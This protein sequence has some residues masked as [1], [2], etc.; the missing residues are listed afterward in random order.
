MVKAIE[1]GI[2]QD[3][4][5]GSNVDVA[6][7]TRGKV[8]YKRSIRSDNKKVYSK[9]DGYTFDKER[10]KVLNEYRQKGLITVEQGAQPMDL[11]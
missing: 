8:E 1:A 3:L 2:Y 11:S 7:I 6:I 9:P 10:V 5:S 4:G